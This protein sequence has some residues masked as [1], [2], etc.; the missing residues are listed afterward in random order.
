MIAEN[1]PFE[2]SVKTTGSKRY[3]IEETGIDV[4][5]RIFQPQTERR[6]VTPNKVVVYLPGWGYN[7]QVK[8]IEPFCQYLAD[9]SQMTTYALD[10]RVER[11][12]PYSLL[13][14][15]RAIS[16]FIEEKGIDDITIAG[17][18]QGGAQAI[19]LTGLLQDRVHVNGIILLDAVSLYTQSFRKFLRNFVL[20]LIRA[21]IKTVY[22]FD[23]NR[24]TLFVN[25][26][27][28][29]EGVAEIAR[30]IRLAG[31]VSRY[32]KRLWNEL[33]EI[34]T[35]NPSA[36][37][38]KVPIVIVHGA[39]DLISQPYKIIPGRKRRQSSS[40]I[41]DI[42]EREQ[43]LQEHLF[44]KSPSVKMIVVQKMGYHALLSLRP[45]QVTRSSL[46]LLERSHRTKSLYCPDYIGQNFA[47]PS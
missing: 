45:D 27:D 2:L 1:R 37:V 11:A 34:C 38:I 6:S 14:E 25:T 28:M 43:F 31:G 30:Q 15:A 32:F 16:Q 24:A 9:Y 13:S 39:R 4:G 17:H 19:H 10:T 12:I 7:E 29:Q 44:P 23:A 46:Y 35:L 26:Q 22:P 21:G 40:Y 3:Q 18:S 47:N 20:E 5:W 33:T 36:Q 8:A 41:Q 42:H